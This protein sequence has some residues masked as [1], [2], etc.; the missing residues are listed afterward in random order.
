MQ[1]AHFSTLQRT[2]IHCSTL[3]HTAAHQSITASLRVSTECFLKEHSNSWCTATH[4]IALHHTATHCNTLQHTATHC[5]TPQH[6]ATHCNTLQHTA[7]HCNTLQHTATHCN[8]LVC[9]YYTLKENLNSWCCIW[10][11]SVSR[12][13]QYIWA[14][15]TTRFPPPFFWSSTWISDAALGYRVAK[16]HGIPYLCRSF[17]AKVTYI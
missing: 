14:T 12:F 1:H 8:T 4:V 9:G 10:S 11:A 2:T 3:Q 5:N 7:T 13:F 15:V 17:P 16:T 6:T